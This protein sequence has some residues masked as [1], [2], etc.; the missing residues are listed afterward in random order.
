MNEGRFSLRKRGE[1]KEEYR[2]EF[3]PRGKGK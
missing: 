2:V 3:R 1:K